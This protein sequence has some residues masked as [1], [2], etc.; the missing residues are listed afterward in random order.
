LHRFIIDEEMVEEDSERMDDNLRQKMRAEALRH[1]EQFNEIKGQHMR[2]KKN[3][4]EKVTPRA[5]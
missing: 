5:C 2:R 3:S 1:L 4:S